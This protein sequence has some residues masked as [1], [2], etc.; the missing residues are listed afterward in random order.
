MRFPIASLFFLV[1]S[2]IF[3]VCWAV[4]SYMLGTLTDEMGKHTYLLGSFSGEY[5]SL[6]ALLPAA[7]GVISA[8]FFVFGILLFFI[9][10][11]L[12]DEYEVYG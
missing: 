1:F 9:L 5:E 10:D 7:F 3:F 6:L 11:A 4:A 8:L 2:F 12:S